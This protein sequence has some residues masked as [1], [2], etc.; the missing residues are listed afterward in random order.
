MSDTF[1]SKVHSSWQQ[2]GEDEIDLLDWFFILW[3]NKRIIVAVMLISSVFGI[4]YAYSAKQVWMASANVKSPEQKDIFPIV[5]MAGNYSAEGFSGFPD[6]SHLY[7]DFLLEYNSE[8]NK[9]AFLTKVIEMYGFG[10]FKSDIGKK[11]FIKA[12]TPMITAHPFDVKKGGGGMTLSYSFNAPENTFLF[13]NEYIDFIVEQQTK[14]L[15][16]DLEANRNIQISTLKRSLRNLR[17]DTEIEL[18]REI[19]NTESNLLIAK[20]ATVTFPLENFDVNGERFPISLGEKGL[21]EKLKILKN[22]K[23][24]AYQPK[25]VELEVKINR[26]EKLSFT[27]IKFRPYSYT[28]NPEV[29]SDREKPKRA[30]IIMMSIILGLMLGVLFVMAKNILASVI[31]R[32]YEQN[33]KVITD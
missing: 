2:K 26:L 3:R 30:L 14:K 13:F 25:I 16:G 21:E 27:G 15:V 18:Q 12:W 33:I 31:K 9:R 32:S 11:D 7:R 17:Y 19:N 22:I 10:E 4:A 28:S 24:E 6:G 5:S 20:A 1:Y 8:V 23:L 29:S